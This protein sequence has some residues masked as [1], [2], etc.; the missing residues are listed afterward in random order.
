MQIS[1]LAQYLPS[2]PTPAEKGWILVSVKSICEWRAIKKNER[3]LFW[4]PFLTLE[5][6]YDH[7]SSPT[8]FFRSPPVQY[9]DALINT[10][11]NTPT[12]IINLINHNIIITSSVIH[13]VPSL[14]KWT[15][16]KPWPWSAKRSS[17]LKII[18]H[19]HNHHHRQHHRHH[20]HH[21]LV[22]II[23][24]KEFLGGFLTYVAIPTCNTP[25][26]PHYLVRLQF[27]QM[28]FDLS[29]LLASWLIL[30]FDCW[31]IW[32]EARPFLADWPI[33][34]SSRLLGEGRAREWKVAPWQLLLLLILRNVST[35]WLYLPLQVEG[36]VCTGGDDGGGACMYVCVCVWGGTGGVLLV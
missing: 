1:K 26:C 30:A 19:H 23:W 4:R 10:M 31:L 7:S 3:R 14:L 15:W 25:E 11:I 34:L 27:C 9:N 32:L 17:C 13:Q 20:H 12:T 5:P 8:Y 18:D 22:I 2:F 6:C 36:V 24:N 33:W 29:T 21:W 28:I 16:L 35:R